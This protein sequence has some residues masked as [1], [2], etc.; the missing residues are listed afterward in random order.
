MKEIGNSYRGNT[1]NALQRRQLLKRRLVY[2]LGAL[3]YIAFDHAALAFCRPKSH[4]Q[5]VA[6]LYPD[7]LGDVL[8]WLPYGQS[9]AN[10]LLREG[11][12]VFVICEEANRAVLEN[13]FGGWTVIG[14]H[15]ANFNLTGPRRRA[16]LL[17]RLRGL[18][19]GRTIYMKYPRFTRK[20]AESFIEALGAPAVAFEA[21]FRNRPRWEILWSNRR[22]ERLVKTEGGRDTHVS[23]HF[24]AFLQAMKVDLREIVP[25]D[26]KV[27]ST[28][29][30]DDDY[31][32]LAPGSGQKYRNW[33][34]ERFATV[35]R[36]LAANRPHWRCVI[37]GTA[38]EHDLGTQI[39]VK[40]GGGALNLTGQTS[41]QQLIDLIAHARLLL[42]ND[43]GAGH[44]AA[45]LGTPAVV[46]VGGGHWGLCFPYPDNA[47]VRRQPVV[48][49]HRMAC[50]G[51][52]WI[53]AH[54]TQT[55]KPFP[56]IEAVSVEAVWQQVKALLSTSEG[57]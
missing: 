23:I 56:C 7:F 39:A 44:I 24:H 3:A 41:V 5:R 43:S 19:V 26:L 28:Q 4:P 47:P 49:G 57:G 50:F 2:S 36:V 32:V 1:L 13:A 51:C 16:E 30:I 48:V 17:R 21:A 53:C 31:W 25:A 12:E 33:P 9:L 46:V 11:K 6:L 37:V 10:H 52:D 20:S 35:A 55:D 15:R 40:L 42:G 34:A 14:I 18:G 29:P 8:I 27:S 38:S 54:T 22:Y 45:A